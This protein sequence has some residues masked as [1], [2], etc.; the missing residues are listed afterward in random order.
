M[1]QYNETAHDKHSNRCK[2]VIYGIRRT[3][4]LGTLE[5]WESRFASR[6]G[7]Q[8]QNLNSPN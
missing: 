5:R 7:C 1:L 6:G 2:I 4:T 8:D 3:G